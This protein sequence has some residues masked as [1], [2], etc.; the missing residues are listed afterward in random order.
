MFYFI[1]DE[2]IT[3]YFMDGSS[4]IWKSS[5]PIFLRVKEL[6]LQSNW[7]E[8]EIL[9]NQA[10][11]LL[12]S[13]VVIRGDEIVFKL[14]E[15]EVIKQADD[16]LSSFIVLLKNKGIIDSQIETIKPF[17]INMFENPYIDAVTE[18]YDYCTAMDFEITKDG[19]FLAYKNVRNDLGS[20]YDGGETKHVIGEYTEVTDFVT[21]RNKTCS[22]GL[23]FCSKEYLSSYTGDV[24]L[25]VKVNPKD[26]VSIPVDYSFQKGRCKRYLPIGVIGKSGALNTVNIGAMTKGQVE[27]IK[28]ETKAKQD[29]EEAQY[30]D[31][32]QQTVE[33]M[34]FYKNPTTVSEIM[35]ISVETVGRN[36]RKARARGSHDY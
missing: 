33:L 8:I 20:I 19:C 29:N 1:D 15:D 25:V 21:D 9:H 27:T 31:R 23:H 5:N 7:L 6:A 36:L 2:Q 10:K 16:P 3:V 11:A 24:T 35:G 34:E 30:N 13:E 26:V 17:L 28:T 12:N 32:I 14:G 18:I 22:R 4:A